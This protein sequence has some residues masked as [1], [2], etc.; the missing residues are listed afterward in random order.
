MGPAFVNETTLMQRIRLR[1]TKLGYRIFRNNC[2]VGWMGTPCTRCQTILRRV[3]FGVANPG[4]SDLVGWRPIKVTPE[5]VGSTLAM[6]CAWEIKLPTGRVTE[7][8]DAF[9]DAVTV[10]GGDARVVR[11]EEQ[12]SDGKPSVDVRA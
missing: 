3:R 4:G 10:A 6:F 1:A 12:I 5:M 2:G 8:Q 7:E 9:L 11:F